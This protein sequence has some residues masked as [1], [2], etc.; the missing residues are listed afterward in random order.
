MQV[1]VEVVGTQRP[2]VTFTIW[3]RGGQVYIYRVWLIR[4]EGQVC[5]QVWNSGDWDWQE[6]PW[7]SGRRAVN[8]RSGMF[9]RN[10]GAPG[11]EV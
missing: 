7:A 10:A 3:Q 1:Q 5:R 6:S 4:N 11:R 9:S 2:T 8:G